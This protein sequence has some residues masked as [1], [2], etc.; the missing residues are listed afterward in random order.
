[1]VMHEPFFFC[2]LFYFP[3]YYRTIIIPPFGFLVLIVEVAAAA[4]GRRQFSME[5]RGRSVAVRHT[6]ELDRCWNGKGGGMIS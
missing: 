1:M 3:R 4:D 6:A 2:I 5:G